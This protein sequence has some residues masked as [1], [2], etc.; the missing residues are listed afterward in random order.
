MKKIDFTKR[1]YLNK[2]SKYEVP[3]NIYNITRDVQNSHVNN[4]KAFLCDNKTSISGM[5]YNTH[6]LENLTFCRCSI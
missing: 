4:N 6:G 3:K 5:I 1:Y 2:H